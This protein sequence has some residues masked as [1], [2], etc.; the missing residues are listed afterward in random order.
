MNALHLKHYLVA[1]MIA[2][3]SLGTVAC[4]GNEPKPDEM[5]ADAPESTPESAPADDGAE[6]EHPEGDE[7]PSEGDEHPSEG[8]GDEHPSGGEHPE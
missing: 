2:A 5:P 8:G 3:F 7:H 4:A 1:L 6:K